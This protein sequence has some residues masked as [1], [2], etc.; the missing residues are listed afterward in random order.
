MTLLFPTLLAGSAACM[1]GGLLLLLNKRT[2]RRRAAAGRSQTSP[3]K[4]ADSQGLDTPLGARLR[5]AS[6]GYTISVGLMREVEIGLSEIPPFPPA[7]MQI[8]QELD[9]AGSSAQSVA[10][11]VARDQSLAAMLLRIAN[12]AAYG[13]Q[14]EI[15]T[16][17][18][19]VAYMG[20]STTKAMFL[21]L[22]M[23]SMFPQ[24]ESGG[25]FDG[26]K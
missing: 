23:S 5:P 26:K 14:R 21:R 6:Q 7:L 13:M 20:F 10:D 16:I 18:E 11:I 4:P 9:D 17:S 24:T 22:R 8:L 15:S 1:G 3:A 12:S 19:A 25:C 2:R